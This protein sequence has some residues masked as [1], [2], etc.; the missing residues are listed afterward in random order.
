M[1]A[2]GS[3]SRPAAKAAVPRSGRTAKSAAKTTKR[4]TSATTTT[5]GRSGRAR[6]TS[7]ATSAR[8]TS[9]KRKPEPA[10]PDAGDLTAA[11]AV[12]RDL[13]TIAKVAP[14]LARSALAASARVLAKELDE[15]G[16]SATSKSMCAKALQDILADLR[17]LTPVGEEKDALDDLAATR[18]RRLGASASKG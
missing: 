13:A 10:T 11:T 17:A 7:A 12:E 15:P 16:N 8:R 5:T 4:G 18:A 1:R 14:E 6:S 9:S 3:T 2:A